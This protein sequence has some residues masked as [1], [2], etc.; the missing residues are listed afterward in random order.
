MAVATRSAERRALV[1]AEHPG[2]AVVDDLAGLEAA[3]AEAVAHLDA[4]RHAHPAYR[5]ALELGLAVVVDKPFALTAA[6]ARSA[7]ELAERLGVLLSVYQNRRWDSDFLPSGPRRRRRGSG[8]V[9][10]MESRF[11]RRPDGPP[12]PG[13]GTLLDFGSH[14]ID[15]ALVLLGRSQ[16]L[17]RMDDPRQRL[18]DDVFVALTHANGARSHHWGSSGQPAPGPRFR[19]AGTEA[20][21]VV[22]GRWTDRRRPRRRPDPGVGGR[23]VGRRAAGPLGPGVR[24]LGRGVPP[25]RP[26]P[27]G[28]LLPGLRRGRP[29]DRPVPVDPRDAVATAEVLDAARTSAEQRELV[30]LI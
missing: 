9:V 18:D 19:V 17:R 16:R 7:V 13:G 20:A 6:D 28:R 30:T 2:A 22:D 10:R 24:R 11:E 27:L 5:E 15:Q 14:L 26:R 3:G 1:N 4:G 21:Y 12:S 25:H 8:R 23:R 29:R